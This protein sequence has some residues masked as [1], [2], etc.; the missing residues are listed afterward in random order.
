MI[1]LILFQM[2][3][4]HINATPITKE[5]SSKSPKSQQLQESFS[6]ESSIFLNKIVQN[7]EIKN[8]ISTKSLQEEPKKYLQTGKFNGSYQLQNTFL[9]LKKIVSNNDRKSEIN[10]Q[11]FQKEATNPPQIIRF[12]RN[13]NSST[14]RSRILQSICARVQN[15]NQFWTHGETAMD[16]LGSQSEPSLHVIYSPC[17]NDVEFFDSWGG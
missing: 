6:S 5:I 1:T 3:L 17:S 14:S 13:P 12:K 7:N 8:E 2:A 16:I 10:S 15:T 4:F 9:V 11:S